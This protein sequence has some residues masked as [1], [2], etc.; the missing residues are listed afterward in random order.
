LA[1]TIEQF[2]SEYPEFA[3]L[4]PSN[5]QGNL[6]YAHRR[7]DP[8]HYGEE[9]DRAIGLLT[10]HLIQIG[11]QGA[12]IMAGALGEVGE[13]KMPAFHR[14]VDNSYTSTGYGLLL[15]D[16]QENLGDI[17]SQITFRVF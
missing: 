14:Q 12:L 13:G 5:I 16:L 15:L 11:Q 7:I 3:S 6:A 2:Q 4:T 8:D 10:A 17:T 1:L 9:T